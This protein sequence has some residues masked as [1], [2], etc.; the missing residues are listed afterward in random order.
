FRSPAPESRRAARA[1]LPP[2]RGPEGRRRTRPRRTPRERRQE[3]GPELFS[4]RDLTSR[5]RGRKIRTHAFARFL[6]PRAV[7]EIAADQ[8]HE[9]MDEDRRPER[10]ADEREHSEKEA[11]ES[12]AVEVAAAEIDV[13]EA[14]ED[15]ADHDCRHGTGPQAHVPHQESAEED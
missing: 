11:G 15:G 6:V 5:Y 14:E 4:L 10:S 12:R 9:R 13:A 3:Q 1:A 2:R 8:V 7:P